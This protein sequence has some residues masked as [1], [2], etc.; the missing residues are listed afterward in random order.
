MQAKLQN[1]KYDYFIVGAGLFG[2]TF[3][4]LAKKAGK[5]RILE[6]YKEELSHNNDILVGGRLESYRYYDMD[7]T[8][9]SAFELARNEFNI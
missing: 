3:A 6:K 1:M 2:P 8:I 4:H 7:E 9:L 5:T